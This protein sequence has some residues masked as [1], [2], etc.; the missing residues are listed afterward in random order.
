MFDVELN[1]TTLRYYQTIVVGLL[2][3]TNMNK[4]VDNLLSMVENKENV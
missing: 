4:R 1:S 2:K 3:L